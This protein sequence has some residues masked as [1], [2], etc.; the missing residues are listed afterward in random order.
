[1]GYWSSSENISSQHICLLGPEVC[2][3]L[4]QVY[5]RC[6]DFAENIFRA[7]H[8]GKLGLAKRATEDMAGPVAFSQ[9]FSEVHA[10]RALIRKITGAEWDMAVNTFTVI[11]PLQRLPA[12]NPF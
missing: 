6:D 2:E 11:I 7:V 4:Y 1:M 5:L 8:K 9:K 12:R 10:L 3:K